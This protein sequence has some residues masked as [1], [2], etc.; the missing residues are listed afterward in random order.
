VYAL[1]NIGFHFISHSVR[2]SIAQQLDAQSN[3]DDPHELLR[4]LDA[5]PWDAT[6]LIWTLDVDATP[7][8][9]INPSGAFAS[10]AYLRL[11]SF[12]REQLTEGVERVSIP[13]VIA[14]NAS[15]MFGLTVPVIRPQIRGM[16]SWTT[17]ALISAVAGSP[18]A[19]GASTKNRDD[20]NRKVQAVRNFLERVYYELRNRGITPQER[21]INYAATNAFAVGTIFQSAISDGMELDAIEVERS[22]ICRPLSDCWDVKLR[23]FDP[24]KRLERAAK[25][26]RLTVDVSAPYPVRYGKVYGWSTY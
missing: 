26:Y 21:A 12:L 6:A 4:Y 3:P 13:G 22:P 23:F 7:I 1:G 20:Y 5:N 9:A 14:G 10:D 8:Y 15:L 2:D 24:Q 16:Y 11:R 17:A 18:P 19:Q 25:L